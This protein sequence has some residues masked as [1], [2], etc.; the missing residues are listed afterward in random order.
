MPVSHCKL[1]AVA[2][3]VVAPLVAAAQAQFSINNPLVRPP[4][5]GLA[6]PVPAAVK[7]P[8]GVP[9]ARSVSDPSSALPPPWPAAGSGLPSQ[10]AE[11]AAKEELS[12]YTV[13]AIVGDA[14]VLRTNVGFVATQG[15]P[16]AGN[17]HSQAAPLGTAGNAQ[18]QAPRQHALRVRTGQ[19]I[20]VGGASVVPTVSISTVEFRSA[21]GKAALLF[22]ASLDSQS[23]QA[24]V[25]TTR[26]AADPAVAARA[27]PTP[28]TING[29]GTPAT[30][31]AGATPGA[32]GAP[33]VGR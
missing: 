16:A 9:V 14:A 10:S 31:A 11:S 21:G 23:P 7:E 17:A 13:V 29:M 28:P 6:A 18:Q 20:L 26:E 4:S 1:I 25:P 27:T 33:A 24:F 22:T 15:T 30:G 32:A 12:A 2:T 5:R 3:L 8:P 19:A